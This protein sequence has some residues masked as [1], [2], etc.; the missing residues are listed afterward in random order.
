MLSLGGRLARVESQGVLSEVLMVVG[1]GVLSAGLRSLRHPA[2][3]RAGTFGFVL[4][5]FLAGWLIGGNLWTGLGFA[6]TW[7]LLPWLEILTRVR[8]MRL[9]LDRSLESCA[10]PPRATFPAFPELSDEMETGGFEYVE[11]VSWTH[12]DTRQFYRLFRSGDRSTGGAICLVEQSEFMFYFIALRSRAS[13]GRILVTWNYPFSYGLHQLPKMI[14][15]RAGGEKSIEE[16]ILLHRAFL[17]RETGEGL[18]PLE[19]SSVRR[20][21]QDDLRRQL[22]HNLACGILKNTGDSTI[23]YTVRGMFFLWFQF[24]KDFVRFS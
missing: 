21:I 22:D 19:A 24:L 3:F 8:K 17:E 23:G 14:V 18:C 5:S 11:D 7:F 1:V 13:D 16:I 10:P 9:P 15:N 4:T 12:G 20:D 6:S 2:F